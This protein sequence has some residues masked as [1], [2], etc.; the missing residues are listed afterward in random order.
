MNLLDVAWLAT[1]GLRAHPLRAALNLFGIVIG[2][3]A[4]VVV[5]G[6]VRAVSNQTR[7]DV[8]GLGADVLVVYP[9]SV[10]SS[11]VQ[12]GFGTGDTLTAADVTALSGGATVPD[13]NAAVPTAG[14]RSQ[15]TYWDRN[16]R[17]DVVGSSDRFAEVRGYS[18]AAGR[19]VDAADVASAAPVVVIGQTVA[20]NLFF[21]DDAVGRSLRIGTVPYRIVGVFAP[22]GASGT[23]NADDLAVVP[24]T[25]MWDRLLPKDSPRIQQ[26]LVRATSASAVGAAKREVE[27]RLLQQHHIGN[28]VDAD[29]RVTSQDDLVASTHR[30]DSLL[31]WMLAVVAAVSLTAG[32]LGIANVML[33]S[34]HER[35]YE[36][37]V[38]RAFGATRRHIAAQFLLEALVLVAGGGVAGA[39]LG[40]GAAHLLPDLVTGIPPI[41]TPLLAMGGALLLSLGVGVLAGVAPSLRAAGLQPVHAIR[42]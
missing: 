3:A 26:I 21:G 7:H 40:G 19:F 13:A 35:T 41:G 15:L 27:Q 30:V 28:P 4:T 34:V 31:A 42:H 20:D 22:R 10:S 36:I 38:R 5:I 14:L 33:A 8:E 17:T 9:S 32:A 6:L 37:G 29:F 16:W 12:Q 11:G 39:L 1:R 24:I 25:S 18:I 2:V 23:V